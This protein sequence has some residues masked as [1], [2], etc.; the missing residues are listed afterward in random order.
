MVPHKLDFLSI[1][2]SPKNKGYGHGVRL[3]PIGLGSVHVHVYW[4]SEQLAHSSSTVKSSQK[5]F[6]VRQIHRNTVYIAVLHKS[7]I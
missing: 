3:G 1:T 7:K 4:H 5:S 2:A 6:Y